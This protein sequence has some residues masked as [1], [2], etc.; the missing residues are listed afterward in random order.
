MEMTLECSG[1]HVDIKQASS[2]AELLLALKQEFLGSVPAWKCF[3]LRLYVCCSLQA[4][5][6]NDAGM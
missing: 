3:C 4:Y 6:G 1:K 2:T 5:D